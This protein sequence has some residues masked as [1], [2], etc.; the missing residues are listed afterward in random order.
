LYYPEFLPDAALPPGLP[1]SSFAGRAMP[2]S[3]SFGTLR[4]GRLVEILLYTVRR[5]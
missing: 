5:R 3:E 4:Y 1:G 2:I